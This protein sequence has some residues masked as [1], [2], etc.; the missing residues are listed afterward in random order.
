[1]VNDYYFNCECCLPC[2]SHPVHMGI[3]RILKLLT[4]YS[5]HLSKFKEN[6]VSY[7]LSIGISLRKIVNIDEKRIKKRV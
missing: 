7:I 4:V 2:T 6:L 3:K 1:M 5:P